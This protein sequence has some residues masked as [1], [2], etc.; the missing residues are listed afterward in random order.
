MTAT[1][2]ARSASPPPS[3]P[4]PP[5]APF[6]VRDDLEYFSQ[7][8]DDE[9]MILVQDPVRGTYFRFN[10]LQ[11]AMLRALDG[12]TTLGQ[13]AAA[14]SERFEVEVSVVSAERFIARAQKLMLLELSAYRV[15][16]RAAVKEVGR[17]LRK[18]G[19]VAPS[20]APRA[21]APPRSFAGQ[22]L[23]AAFL[24]LERCHPRA[25]AAHLAELLQRD[26]HDARAR[27]LYSLIQTAYLRA[28]GRTTDFPTWVIFNPSRMLGWLCTA[29]GG[30][31]FSWLGALA[32]LLFVGIG[33]Y[34]YTEVA[35]ERVGF[36]PTEI[37]L[38]IAF[39]TVSGLLHEMGHGLACQRYGGNVTEIGF[40]LFYYVQPAFYCDTSSSY[41]IQERRHRVIVQLAGTVVSLVIMAGLAI[42][43]ALL[44]PSVP[45]YPGLTLVLFIGSALVF[46]NLNPF[47]KFDGYYAIC[48]TL[49]FSNLRDRSSKLVRAW[50]SKRLLGIELPT[51]A[52]SR[53]VRFYL[54]L[55]AM[56]AFA[57][58]VW[59][60]YVGF[61]RVVV[62]VVERYRGLG[63][64]VSLAVSAYLMR[65]LVL[66]PIGQLGALVVRE[67]RRIFTRRRSILLLGVAA[68]VIG[69]WF[70]PWP[71][72]VDAPI[73]IVPQHRADVRAQ[74][75]GRISQ[76]LVAEG[77]HVTGGQPLAVL[78]D[79]ALSASIAVLEAE[80][81]VA[82]HRMERLRHGARAE[83]LLLARRRLSHAQASYADLEQDLA[84]AR[85]LSEASLGT[86]AR[87]DA[88]SGLLATAAATVGQARWT[89]SLL[90]AGA[91]AEELAVAAAEHARLTA[92]LEHR[93][94]EAAL[95][96]L[97]SPI[98]GVVVAPRLE[99]KLHQHLAPGAL[100][101][102]VHDLRS[103][104]GELR[105][106]AGAPLSEL[107][108]GHAVEL[109]LHG[110]PALPIAATVARLREASQAEGGEQRIVAVTSAFSLERP[111]TGMT[112][113]A[114]IY[115]A[116]YSLAYAYFSL[117]LQR[118]LRV[119]L[120][121][122]W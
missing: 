84:L 26:P 113:H 31:L 21:A 93:R 94:S 14:L 96:I 44:Q 78:C 121:S 46:V 27:Q 42:I 104:I 59:F 23:A 79:P 112:G 11:V 3:A 5:V 50:L 68:L 62:P 118:L 41:R 120:W 57:F 49:G 40:T 95:L 38:A 4:P 61:S 36:G 24:E 100:L 85:R 12:R 117:P 9:E 30:F 109:R 19:F 63:L 72:L 80:R 6:K 115:G 56:A 48:D 122:M 17:A 107:R 69:P 71:I 88:A 99:D 102:E 86:A 34:A 16:S 20:L 54:I 13:I 7:L 91:R 55:Y 52:L 29:G 90:S 105:L 10:V 74:V 106:P 51:E 39:K 18:A 76:L 119:R 60:I 98:D 111:L 108:A 77:A 110:A 116:E 33:A 67:R 53:R 1:A 2:P 103:V 32:I 101:A 65:D 22:R 75:P 92:A 81:E 25:A 114:R 87:A 35:F 37:A 64:L 15:T 58:T 89:L 82:W 8:V 43:L 73:V 45:I 66:R 47:L 97:R 70:L 28:A 83:E